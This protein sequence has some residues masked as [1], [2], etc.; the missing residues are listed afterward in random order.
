M[1]GL[2]GETPKETQRYAPNVRVQGGTHHQ[3]LRGGEPNTGMIALWNRDRGTA[4]MLIV[5]GFVFTFLWTMLFLSWAGIVAYNDFEQEQNAFG[6]QRVYAQPP[7]TEWTAEEWAQDMAYREAI[8]QASNSPSDYDEYLRLQEE[9][10]RWRSDIDIKHD[11][12]R[13]AREQGQ[14]EQEK[15]AWP[16][17]HQQMIQDKQAEVQ[18][19]QT[20]LN[21]TYQRGSELLAEELAK[22]EVQA[23]MQQ[24]PQFAT[25]V[26]IWQSCMNSEVSNIT[27]ISFGG[28]CTT[29][30]IDANNRWCG[31][32]QYDQNKCTISSRM[33]AI[34]S[35]LSY[36][37]DL[38][39]DHV[40]NLEAELEQVKST[41]FY[42]IHG[43][44]TQEE[45]AGLCEYESSGIR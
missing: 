40:S 42:E 45:G 24:D 25:F 12:R 30:F 20:G 4:K 8:D 35:T 2:S 37:L 41:T 39:K 29:P 14:R 7:L 36:Y 13:N 16:Q 6:V 19:A 10:E 33:Y 27:T 9:Y 18:E 23:A 31:I 22:K 5:M 44:M 11:E 3:N 17:E 38:W 21:K 43:C 28:E 26:G 15:L 34:L 1:N 32:D